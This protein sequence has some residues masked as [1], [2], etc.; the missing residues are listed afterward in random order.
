M[1]TTIHRHLPDRRARALDAG[2]FNSE[3]P[4][5]LWNAGYRNLQAADLDP[6]GRAIRWYGNR[7]EFRR[8]NFYEAN[9]APDALDAFTALSVIEHGYDQQRLL[10]LIRRVL[11]PGG[12]ACLST[13]YHEEPIAIP[14]DYRIFGLPYR[15]FCRRDIE[16][17]LSEA[18]AQGLTP[19]GD[20]RWEQSEYPI[21]W[22]GHGMTFLFLALRKAS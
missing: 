9:I 8:E 5:A 11:R 7:I 22:L 21:A 20:L 1:L 15:I 10:R 17:L 18:Q 4:L 14:A 19:I 2:S 6:H 16:N 12:I 13:D 3:I